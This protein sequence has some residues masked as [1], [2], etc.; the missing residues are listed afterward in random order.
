MSAIWQSVQPLQ[1]SRRREGRAISATWQSFQALR[2]SPESRGSCNLCNS[3]TFSISASFSK[4][5]ALCNLCNLAI[6]S[7]SANS[8]R[9][10]GQAISAFQ[11]SF[12]QHTAYSNY[13]CRI[14]WKFVTFARNIPELTFLGA[15]LRNSLKIR[16]NFVIFS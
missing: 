13:I 7:T 11:Q 10:R 5:G 1:L 16:Q 15:A 12:Q 9:R 14:V 8:Q 6:F 2:F 3:A 4:A